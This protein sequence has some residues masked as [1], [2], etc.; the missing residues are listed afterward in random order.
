MA[1]ERLTFE[2]NAVGNAVPQ[3]QKVQQQLGNVNR[4]MTQ[5]T[6][7]M[8]RHTR[9][10]HQVVRSNMGLTRGLGLASLQFQDM[11]VQASMGTDALRIMTMQGPQLASIFGPKGMIIGGIIAVGGAIAMMGKSAKSVS[12]DFKQFF[13]DI[14]PAFEGLRP[15]LD[16]L[17][18]AFDAVKEALIFSINAII[19]ALQVMATVAGTVLTR[20]MQH[21]EIAQLKAELVGTRVK[22]FMQQ[23][24]DLTRASPELSGLVIEFDGRREQQTIV[25]SLTRKIGI[26][27][28]YI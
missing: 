6:Q 23:V 25:E 7:V 13:A 12:F 18:I 14:K 28:C 1:T 21:L 3:M 2:M 27:R 19:N 24:K 5:T 22:K 16:G 11:A 9:A 4:Q 8:Q 10:T 17:K 26:R 20:L 15:I